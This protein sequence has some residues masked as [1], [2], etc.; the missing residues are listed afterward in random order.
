MRVPQLRTLGVPHLRYPPV[1]RGEDS[2]GPVSLH[3]DGMTAAIEWTKHPGDPHHRPAPWVGDLVAAVLITATAFLPFPGA[4]FR[5]G[6][7]TATWLVIASVVVLPLRRRW[8][9]QVL[10]AVLAL[11][12]AVA[13]T[14][15]LAPGLALAA[16]V[17]MFGVANRTTRRLAFLA[18]AVSLLTIVALSQL[19][20]VGG[21]FQP[22]VIQ[23]AF[24]VA[25]AAA[26]GDAS[27]S[28]REYVVAMT[29]RA[30][31]AEQNRE[32]EARRRVAEERL[33]IA[34]DLHDAVAHQISVISLNAGVASSALESRPE[35]AREALGA[36]RSASRTVLSE[37]GNL[38]EVLRA[39]EHQ[40]N[41]PVPQPG[42]D[43]MIFSAGFPPSGCPSAPGLMVTSRESAEPQGWW[44]I[45]LSRRASPTRT[46][47]AP[48]TGHTS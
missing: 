11:Y 2:P 43:S 35:K 9:V 16:A 5:P 13:S 28:R 23:F 29:E 36:I 34:R 4:E 44:P 14:G 30:E 39:D 8:P 10:A 47:M 42:L 7:F 33:R 20:A 38:L 6:T 12:G 46:S 22:P 37:I 24:M 21:I 1:L 48:S 41:A 27:R 45:A 32:S 25:F 19:A 31:R 17:A 26:A 15:T 18:A 3:T 40:N